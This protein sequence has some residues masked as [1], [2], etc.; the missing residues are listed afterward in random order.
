MSMTAHEPEGELHVIESV[1]AALLGA[2][3]AIVRGGVEWPFR[4]IL[5]AY[6]AIGIASSPTAGRAKHLSGSGP[7]RVC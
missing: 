7:T 5:R 1:N 6:V 2:T 4:T 3:N